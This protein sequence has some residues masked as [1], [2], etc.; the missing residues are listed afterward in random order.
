MPG[1]ARMGRTTVWL[2]NQC[3]PGWE[4]KPL[5]FPSLGPSPSM[6]LPASQQVLAALSRR[7]HPGAQAGAVGKQPS[8]NSPRLSVL[9]SMGGS[10][11]KLIYQDLTHQDLP[12]QRSYKVCFQTSVV[13]TWKLITIYGWEIPKFG[14]IKKK[15]T[16]SIWN[17]EEALRQIKNIL[18]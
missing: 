18:K 14:G 13:W 10:H 16:S 2:A 17:K 15:H 8:L 1:R 6:S 12:K 5:K 9:L 3:G 4:R 11:E 7:R